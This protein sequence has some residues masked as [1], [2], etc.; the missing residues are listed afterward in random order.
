V[1]GSEIG[2]LRT[3]GARVASFLTLPLRRVLNR[4][5]LSPIARIG[6]VGTDEYPLD[7]G[8]NPTAGQEAATQERQR[9]ELV[10]DI[11]ARRDGEL[12]LYVNDAVVA[13]PGLADLFYRRE[14]GTRQ[15][16]VVRLSRR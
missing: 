9:N 5:W 12:F 8:T 6:A 1:T 16:E 11:R 7:P 14:H 4:P 10:A 15:V 2:E 13:I 3:I